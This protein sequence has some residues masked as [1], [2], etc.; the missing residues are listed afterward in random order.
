MLQD[1]Y[2][3]HRSPPAGTLNNATAATGRFR[4]PP[5][6]GRVRGLGNS[7]SFAAQQLQY[8]CTPPVARY[9]REPQLSQIFKSI[10]TCIVNPPWKLLPSRD[11]FFV[12]LRGKEEALDRAH[13]LCRQA[14]RS[15]SA[16]VLSWLRVS[17]MSIPRGKEPLLPEMC[18]VCHW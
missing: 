3:A 18:L 5:G 9:Q 8:T 13:R 11:Q 6:R 17:R 2:G 1:W 7:P 10:S 16:S 15:G 14:A 12:P 4:L